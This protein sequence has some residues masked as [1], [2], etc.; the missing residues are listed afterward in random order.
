MTSAP[1]MHLLLVAIVTANFLPG[2][3]G[4]VLQLYA[5]GQGQVSSVDDGASMKVIFSMHSLK[6]TV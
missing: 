3:D 2:I 4:N 5:A 1:A 6:S